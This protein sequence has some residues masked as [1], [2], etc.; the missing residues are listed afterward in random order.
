MYKILET[1][2]FP[3]LNEEES[4]NLNRLTLTNKIKTVTKKIP[5][6][7]SPRP[8]GFTGKFY[9]AFKEDLTLIL[10]ELFQKMQKEGQ[11]QAY[12]PKE[13]NREHGNKPRPLCSI[14]S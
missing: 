14:N 11:E 3:K 1:Y 7:K 4:E 12:R 10:L 13:Q 9:Q 6:N 2:N 8:G 5:A